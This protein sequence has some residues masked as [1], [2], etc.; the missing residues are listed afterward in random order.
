MK[1]HACVRTSLAA[2]VLSTH[3]SASE[4]G[5]ALFREGREKLRRGHAQVACALFQRSIEV[6]GERSG[7][8]VN[9]AMCDAQSG[10]HA[11]AL[12]KLSRARAAMREGDP[13]LPL[14][15]TLHRDYSDHVAAVV[16]S[17]GSGSAGITADR[18]GIPIDLSQT[19]V[20]WDAGT[21][22][23]RI[24]KT[25]HADRLER[26][27]VREREHLTL[28]L[29]PG[30]PWPPPPPKEKPVETRVT[31]EPKKQGVGGW[32]LAGGGIMS[33]AASAATGLVALDR[34][35]TFREHC[36]ARGACDPEGLTAARDGKT[37]VLLSS[38]LF[39]VGALL[40]SAGVTWAVLASRP[41]TKTT[42]TIRLDA[43]GATLGGTF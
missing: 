42:S 37:M 7:P 19:V 35:S 40:T 13:R 32:V 17:K 22:L 24:R 26:V 9:L 28:E 16:L 33:L 10:R 41:P 2:A 43:G 3:A 18:D 39:G 34:A 38:V 23:V 11:A 14:L 29:S 12:E 8:L 5:E 21:Y 15:A 27:T 4:S 31:P 36:D 30:E 6:D 25:G 1:L 20:H